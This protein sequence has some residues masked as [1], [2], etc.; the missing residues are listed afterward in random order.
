MEEA[1]KLNSIIRFLLPAAVLLLVFSSCTGRDRGNPDDEVSEAITAVPVE[2][3][4]INR[5]VLI[6]SVTFS[7]VVEGGREATVVSET[8]GRIEELSIRLGAQ[9]AAGDVLLRV[10]DTV[11]RLNME[12][13]RQQLETARID[14]RSKEELFR[15]GA[16]SRAE[17]SR[18]QSAAA[19]AEAAY[20]SAVKVFEDSSVVS[21]IDG[22]VAFIAD[23]L[24]PGNYLTRGARLVRIVDIDRLVMKGGV[25]E[26]LVSLVETG[27]AASVVIPAACG[28][29][30]F[31][32]EVTAVASGSDPATGSFTVVVEWDNPCGQRVKSG[33]SASADI[34]PSRMETELMVPSSA[35]LR[36]NG[37][38]RVLL[39]E[40]GIVRTALIEPGSSLGNRTV[41]KSGLKEDDVVL[42]SGLSSLSD[43]DQVELS[44]VGSSGAWK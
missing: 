15:G 32:A 20:R 43:G 18:S 40:E 27:A 28:E 23:G 4:R 3:V 31:D 34:A 25:G 2:G 14:L 33:M 16:V 17:L 21:P 36:R 12:Q 1:M 24:S 35:V 5:G 39:A 26:Q 8:Q 38:S 30:V 42:I 10:D 11:A 19:G 7:G 29:Q 37:E 44:I 41:V 13:A 22:Y 9:V 6:D